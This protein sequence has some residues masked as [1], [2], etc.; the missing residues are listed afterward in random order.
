VRVVRE[1][2]ERRRGRRVKVEGGGSVGES[3]KGAEIGAKLG[4]EKVARPE[5]V[6]T[7]ARATLVDKCWR[8]GDSF[9]AV[10]CENGGLFRCS[11]GVDGVE[12]VRNLADV[13]LDDAVTTTN[14]AAAR[15]LVWGGRDSDGRGTRGESGREVVQGGGRGGKGGDG[16]GGGGILE[17]ESWGGAGGLGTE[18]VT[19]TGAASRLGKRRCQ[20]PSGCGEGEK[21]APC[22]RRLVTRWTEDLASWRASLSMSKTRRMRRGRRRITWWRSTGMDEE[23]RKKA[24]FWEGARTRGR[25]GAKEW[26]R[27]TGCGREGRKGFEGGCEN[28]ERVAL[29]RGGSLSWSDVQSPRGRRASRRPTVSSTNT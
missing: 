26:K 5:V 19:T 29:T 15:G 6:L 3:T 7:A 9:E 1:R 21:S 27:G 13:G 24:I 23:G 25:S 8:G 28:G 14:A 20:P 17:G 4:A 12:D 2:E 16:D 22:W 11:T 10:R 18:A